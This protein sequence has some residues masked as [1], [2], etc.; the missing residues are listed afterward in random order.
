MRMAVS[1]MYDTAR[2]V[3]QD[4]IVPQIE[5]LAGEMTALRPEQHRSA[6]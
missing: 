5:G 2:Q 4:I 6:Y 3:F 1:G